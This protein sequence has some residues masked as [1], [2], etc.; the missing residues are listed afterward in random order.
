MGLFDRKK[1]K[2]DFSNVH[3]GGSTTDPAKSAKPG[4]GR[5]YTVQKGDTLSQIAEH[6]YGSA[7]KWRVIYEANR[8][9]IKDPDLI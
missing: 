1:V 3:S 9:L 4:P 5:S 2:P 6:F 7:S 8:D